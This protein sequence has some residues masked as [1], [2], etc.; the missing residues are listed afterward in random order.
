MVF[1]FL[2]PLQPPSCFRDIF[3]IV[4]TGMGQHLKH[5][6]VVSALHYF[7]H[8][9]NHRL[10]LLFMNLLVSRLSLPASARPSAAQR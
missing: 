7:L 5:I 9:T 6:T 10:K 3:R 2:S 8:G 4:F 1:R